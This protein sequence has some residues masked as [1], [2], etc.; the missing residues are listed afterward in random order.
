MTDGL[1]S[2]SLS[3][4][5]AGRRSSSRERSSNVAS[6]A[7]ERSHRPW[8]PS[9]S[10]PTRQDVQSSL[11]PNYI[12]DVEGYNM[13]PHA[14]LR[15]LPTWLAQG[16]MDGATVSSVS[17]TPTANPSLS[18]DGSHSTKANYTNGISGEDY[19]HL[20]YRQPS[21]TSTAFPP[22]S[23]S[24]PSSIPSSSPSSSSRP[25]SPSRPYE[26]PSALRALPSTQSH[27]GQD[28]H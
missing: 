15:G 13:M 22:P 24:P 3:S 21:A 1:A 23:T 11:P 28:F 17:A 10:Q 6:V 26:L 19:S 27:R 7:G 20:A 4:S 2:S 14:M 25:F 5:H 18:S 12:S 9:S 8:L 16:S